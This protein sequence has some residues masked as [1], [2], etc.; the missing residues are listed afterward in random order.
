[1]LLYLLQYNNYYNRIVKK[2]SNIFSYMDYRVTSNLI[3]NPIQCN[4]NPNDGITTKQIINWDGDIPDY[5]VASE[6]GN[7][8]TSRWFVIEA[9][10]KRGQQYELTLYRDTIVDYYQNVKKADVFIE[11]AMLNDDDTSNPLLFNAENMSFNQIKYNDVKLYDKTKCPWLI[12]FISKDFDT[13]EDISV[14][15]KNVPNTLPN[16][17]NVPSFAASDFSRY[18]GKWQVPPFQ[19]I[20]NVGYEYVITSP[21]TDNAT[22]SIIGAIQWRYVLTTYSAVQNGAYVASSL[23]P[24]FSEG[25]YSPM[26]ETML[27]TSELYGANDNLEGQSPFQVYNNNSVNWGNPPGLISIQLQDYLMTKY[28][29]GLDT[30][31]DS[32][33]YPN[34]ILVYSEDT[35]KLYSGTRS[36]ISARE[37]IPTTFLETSDDDALQ[38]MNTIKNSFSTSIPNSTVP[39]QVNNIKSTSFKITSNGEFYRY[40][41]KEISAYN[42]TINIAE[43]DSLID[44]PFD[45]FCMPYSDEFEYVDTQGN[46]IGTSSKEI[47]LNIFQSIS[48]NGTPTSIYDIQIVPYCPIISNVYEEDGKPRI[49]LDGI[50]YTEIKQKEGTDEYTVGYLYWAKKSKDSFT[51]DYVIPDVLNASEKK[52]KSMT[53]FCRLTSPSQG[54]EF[55]F[56]PMK[57]NG[58]SSFLVQYHYKPYQSNIRIV[59]T[60]NQNSLYATSNIQNSQDG[61]IIMEDMSLSQAT[62]KWAEYEL[63][64]KNYRSAFQR[65][66]QSMELD[67]NWSLGTGIANT[68]VG[69]VSGAAGGAATGFMIGGGPIGA[70]VGAVAGGVAS[71]GGGITD[72]IQQQALKNDAIDLTKDNFNFML[73]NIKALPL[74]LNK[75]SSFNPN[76]S[77]VP[78]LE[79]WSATDKEKNIAENKIIFNGMTI[80]AI[81][82]LYNYKTTENAYFKGQ[83]I[84]LN[85]DD[86]FHVANTI[87][88]ELYQGLYLN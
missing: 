75:T 40:D 15:S 18:D 33:F 17:Y 10:R 88:K 68:L 26:L 30:W 87:A 51:I 74:Q 62:D 77:L 41:F 57:N 23:V 48:K 25:G 13:Q 85:I 29:V 38:L 34:E 84:R 46:I 6:T 37:I 2:E 7:E 20:G 19:G 66:I 39:M 65:Q 52:V 28:Q 55:V 1:M 44:Q 61:L 56:D 42:Y 36:T 8:I 82:N 35:G 63:N 83:I 5:I 67:K 50:T 71:L 64:N 9:A 47:N 21:N 80:G 78:I 70:A 59:P 54:S 81:D 24:Y 79:F 32:Y 73:G 14:P 53:E 43:R 12:G 49:S 3:N 60:W 16:V 76:N 4:F 22:S 58:V 72:L 45:M 31:N 27:Q 11:K 86:D 69:S